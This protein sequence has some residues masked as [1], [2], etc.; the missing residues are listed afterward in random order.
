MQVRVPDQCYGLQTYDGKKHDADKR[1]LVTLDDRYRRDIKLA[2]KD[3]DG[4][5]PAEGVMFRS[6]AD[7]PACEC[8]FV[9]WPWQDECPRCHADLTVLERSAA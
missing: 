6:S 5:A 3:W 9:P 4:I 7:D 2:N 1:G 8:G